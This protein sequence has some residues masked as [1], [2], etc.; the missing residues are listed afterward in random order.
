MSTTETLQCHLSLA[1]PAG[2][3]DHARSTPCTATLLLL[4]LQNPRSKQNARES[5]SLHASVTVANNRIQAPSLQPLTSTGT[6][7]TEYMGGLMAANHSCLRS[8]GA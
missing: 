1:P 6:M 7:P 8:L 5:M 4:L 2:S 3:V